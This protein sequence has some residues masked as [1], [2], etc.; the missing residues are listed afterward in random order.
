VMTYLIVVYLERHY[1]I[2][3]DYSS[4]WTAGLR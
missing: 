3:L 4:L 1:T 2:V